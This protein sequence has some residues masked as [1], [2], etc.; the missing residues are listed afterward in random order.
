[1]SSKKNR[2]KSGTSP[3]ES[4]GVSPSTSSGASAVGGVP[5]RDPQ[6]GVPA[7]VGLAR[8][9]LLVAFGLTCYLATASFKSGGLAGCGPE[10]GCGEVL[11]SRWAYW[12]G[13]PVS[14]PA[15]LLYLTL[16]GL[17]FRMG[18]NPDGTEPRT[19]RLL[20]QTGCVTVIGA[21]LWFVSL[22]AFAVGKFCPFCCATHGVA[23]VASVILLRWVGAMSGADLMSAC[24]G[25]AVTLGILAGGQFAYEPKTFNV[26]GMGTGGTNAVAAQGASNAVPA[27]SPK[28]SSP[29]TPPVAVKP[30]EPPH[31]MI[32]LHNGRFNIDLTEYPVIGSPTAPKVMVSLFDYTCKYCRATHQPIV[33]VQQTFSNELA[34]LSLP[35]PLDSMC[36]R[37]VRRTPSAHTN[38]CQ[39]AAIALAVFRADRAKFRQ[40]DEWLMSTLPRTTI[41]QARLEAVALVGAPSLDKALSDPWIGKT[42]QM[43]IDLYGANSEAGRSGN[44]PQMIIGTNIVSG[45]ING[46]NGLFELVEKGMGLKR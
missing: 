8:L 31:P 24:A 12:L 38:A 16:L 19:S 44:M 9:L 41:D 26:S 7:A 36:N 10:G 13:V 20:L 42:I 27:V 14:V 1:M 32:E 4:S 28:P 34:V 22:Q 15:G 25:A 35:M 6:K 33:Q 5:G 11:R 2:P 18:K 17:T 37:F 40:Y 3:A 21:G 23:A 39:F 45:T 46:V 29:V 30:A 43:A